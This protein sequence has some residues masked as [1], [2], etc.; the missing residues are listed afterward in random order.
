[1]ARFDPRFSVGKVGAFQVQFVGLVD[2]Q[3]TLHAGLQRSE[4]ARQ[5][6]GVLLE[7]ALLGTVGERQ[8]DGED[9]HYLGHVAKSISH[10]ESLKPV[11]ASETFCELF[12]P[13]LSTQ[14]L[15]QKSGSSEY[16]LTSQSLVDHFLLVF[17]ITFLIFLSDDRELLF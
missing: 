9:R 4:V 16:N 8:Q 10:T 12:Q 7:D 5:A 14:S 15:L 2:V 11:H 1:M 17:P 13:T 3:V 6:P